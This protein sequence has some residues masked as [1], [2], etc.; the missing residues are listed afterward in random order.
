VVTVTDL[1]TWLKMYIP[2]WVTGTSYKVGDYVISSSV[3]YICVIAHTGGTFATDLTAGKWRISQLYNSLNY[4]LA[5]VRNYTGRNFTT[6]SVTE[7]F[8]GKGNCNFYPSELP[9][10]EITEINYYDEDTSDWVTIFTGSDTVDD[11]VLIKNNYTVKLYNGYWFVEGTEYQ[12]V[13]TGGYVSGSEPA[14]VKNVALEQAI[15]N[16]FN[17]DEGKSFFALTSKNVGSQATSSLQYESEDLLI[18]RHY[19]IL[20]QYRNVNI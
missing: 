8:T 19:K 12:I 10:T 4:G 6:G 16:Y 11:S 1:I 13:Y 9:A 7:Y 2:A 18:A 5:F 20:D 3:I 17:S 14:D 15:R